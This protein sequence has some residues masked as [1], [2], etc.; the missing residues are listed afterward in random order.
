MI[1]SCRDKNVLK[2]TREFILAH[3]TSGFHFRLKLALNKRLFYVP[4]HSLI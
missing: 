1:S 2:E 4:S 3:F